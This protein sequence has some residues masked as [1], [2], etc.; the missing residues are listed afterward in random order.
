MI[1]I[2]LTGPKRTLYLVEK[3]TTLNL[4]HYADALRKF[5]QTIRRV[6]VDGDWQVEKIIVHT[7]VRTQDVN[8]ARREDND[9]NLVILDSRQPGPRTMEDF[10]LAM[11]DLVARLAC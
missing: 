10:R 5:D 4:N 3:R 2:R 9:P 11:C 1:D 8:D 7:G 6:S